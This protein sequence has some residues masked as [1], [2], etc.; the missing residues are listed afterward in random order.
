MIRASKY[1]DIALS[2]L[3]EVRKKSGQNEADVLRTSPS[4]GHQCASLFSTIHSIHYCSSSKDRRG[5]K[6]SHAIKVSACLAHWVGACVS[7]KVSMGIHGGH[8]HA[9]IY[10]SG[11]FS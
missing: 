11:F 2:C 6:K 4:H 8:S 7:Q 10:N 3:G 1:R 5:P 9:H